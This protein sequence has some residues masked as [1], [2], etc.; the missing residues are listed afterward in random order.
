MR[1]IWTIARREYT[2]FFISPVAYIV[3][4]LILGIIGVSFALNIMYIQQNPYG[5]MGY[6]PDAGI[7]TGP[8]AFLLVLSVPAL[9]MRLMADEQRMGTME[10]LLTA[11]VRDWELV[12]GKWLGGFLFILTVVAVSLIYPLAEHTMIDNGLEWGPALSSY[13]GLILVAAAFMGLGVG[14]SSLFSNP[15]AAFFGSLVTFAFFW[16]IVGWPSSLLQ[17]GGEF[18]RYMSMSEHFNGSLSNGVIAVG[19]VIY[20]LSLT[21][22]GIFIGSMAVEIRRWR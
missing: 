16:W 21:S 10:L 7:V 5:A 14:I 20:Y 15:I 11:P 2:H 13:L 19:D 3:A 9:S 1:N 17:V 22:L 18:F 4:L 6:V 12:T 8:F